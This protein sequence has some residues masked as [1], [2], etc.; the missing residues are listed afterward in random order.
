MPGEDPMTLPTPEEI[1]PKLASL[2]SPEWNET[3]KLFHLPEGKLKGF[4]GPA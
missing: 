2:C 3:G 1:A 4:Q